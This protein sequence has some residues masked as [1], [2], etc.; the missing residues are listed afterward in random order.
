MT[1]NSSSSDNRLLAR[2]QLIE[3]QRARA[4]LSFEQADHDQRQRSTANR[5]RVFRRGPW[6]LAATV[7]IGLGGAMLMQPFAMSLFTY[8]FIT[9][10]AG[11]V[12]FIIV[13]HFPD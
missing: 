6:E 4:P 10:L 3:T 5:Q 13:S 9:I 2:R 7:L 1:A 11:T 8:S 12:M